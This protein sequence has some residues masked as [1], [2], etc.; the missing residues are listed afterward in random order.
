MLVQPFNVLYTEGLPVWLIS[1]W[2]SLPVGFIYTGDLPVSGMFMLEF[3]FWL[4]LHLAPSICHFRCSSRVC[5]RSL[6]YVDST[7]VVG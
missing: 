3:S 7:V 6:P 2:R 5:S 4:L 1:Y